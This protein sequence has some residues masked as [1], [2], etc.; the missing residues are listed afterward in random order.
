M[1]ISIAQ[2]K[3]IISY[4]ENYTQYYNAELVNENG[5]PIA[6]EETIELCK[7]KY[8]EQETD[9][10]FDEFKNI[11]NRLEY[12]I[13]DLQEIETNKSENAYALGERYME[14][15]DKYGFERKYTIEFEKEMDKDERN[16][17]LDLDK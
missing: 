7:E 1:C 16:N 15:A 5:K 4:A 9:R 10:A 6:P 17:E 8:A 14:L 2:K 3:T 12:L 13:T 11:E